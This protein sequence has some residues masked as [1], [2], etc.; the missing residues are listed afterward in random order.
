MNIEVKYSV[1]S[2]LKDI[3]VPNFPSLSNNY[4]CKFMKRKCH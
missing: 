1:P 4:K 3:V 2:S